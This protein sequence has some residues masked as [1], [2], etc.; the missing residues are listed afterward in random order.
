MGCTFLCFFLF[1]SRRFACST[2]SPPPRRFHFFL[3]FFF[4]PLGWRDVSCVVLFS[5]HLS[6]L[7]IFFTFSSL[8]FFLVFF[9][10]PGFCLPAAVFHALSDGGGRAGSPHAHAL[11]RHHVRLRGLQ[12]SIDR[13]VGC[14]MLVPFL[15]TVSFKSSNSPNTT[16]KIFVL[17]NPM[18]Q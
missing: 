10:F 1:S 15:E 11:L 4:F 7:G 12:G 3:F 13:S 8:Y 16:V 14:V 2:L 18:H 5:A 6:P 9:F 17:N